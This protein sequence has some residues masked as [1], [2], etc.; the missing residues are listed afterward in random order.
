MAV[1]IDER[2]QVIRDLTR[3]CGDGRLTLDE[4]EERIEEAYAASTPEELRHVLRDLPVLRR[5]PDPVPDPEPAPTS[6]R[7][8]PTPTPVPPTPPELPALPGLPA[9]SKSDVE[10]SIGALICIGG[11]VLLFNGMFWLAMICWFVLPGLILHN[12]KG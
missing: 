12:R 7:P 5:E 8:A 10:K 6:W 4:L 1:L 11:F 3:H 2:E 9:K